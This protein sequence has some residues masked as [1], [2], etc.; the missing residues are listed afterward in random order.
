[1]STLHSPLHDQHV[2][3]GAS[4]VDFA[5]WEMPLRYGGDVAEHHAVRRAAGLF[6]LSHMGELMVRGADAAA[7]LD[8]ALVG[9]M[10]RMALGRAKYTMMCAP[11][12]GVLDDLVV[13]R[14][15][16]DHFMVVANAANRVQVA[17]EL[18]ARFDAAALDA[19]VEDETQSIA[20]IAVQ[21]PASAGIVA[22]MCGGGAGDVDPMRYYSGVNLLLEGG[23]HAY[24]ARTGYTGEDGFELFVAADTA[25]DVWRLALREGAAAGLEPCGLAA[26]DSLRLEAGMPLYG[27]ELSHDTTP[28]EAGLGRVVSFGVS[29]GPDRGDFVG[30]EALARLSEEGVAKTLVGLVGDGRRAARTGYAVTDGDDN[31]VGIVT[32]GLPSPTLGQLI[33]MAYVPTAL[34]EPGT[35]VGVDVRGRREEMR[36]VALPFYQRDA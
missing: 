7:A 24:A 10:S 27:H 28:F 5:G 35:V 18:Q 4:L 26:R 16:W 21:G 32:S 12:G 2:A 8:Y 33:A 36:V 31:Q 19:T 34:A 22:R 13:Y 11:D 9:H 23:I 20:L 30:R 1:M 6:D 25:G 17:A 14:R 3:L 15:D 29:G